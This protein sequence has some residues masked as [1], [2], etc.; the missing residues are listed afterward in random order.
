MYVTDCPMLSPAS[1]RFNHRLFVARV[2]DISAIAMRVEQ[3]LNL[4]GEIRA[5][6]AR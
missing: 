4:G 5:L 6:Y 2:L 1:Q 3:Y